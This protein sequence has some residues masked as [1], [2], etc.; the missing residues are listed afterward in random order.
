MISADGM[1][2]V[3]FK[4]LNQKEKQ[5]S[6]ALYEDAFPEDR[7]AYAAYYYKWKCRDNEIFALIDSSR[8]SICAMLHLNPYRIWISTDSMILHY[9]VAVATAL[10]YRR[11]GCMRRLML[12]AFFWL[13]SRGEPFTYLMPADTAYYEPFGFRVIYDQK[14]VSFPTDPERANDWAREQ[15]DVVTMR[16]EAYMQFLEEEPGSN[17]VLSTESVE[18]VSDTGDGNSWKPQIMCRI[19]YLPRLLT[20][21]RADCPRTIYLQVHDLLIEGNNGLYRW[22][23]DREHSC[24]TRIGDETEVDYLDISI[25]DLAE[26]LFGIAPLHPLLSHIRVLNRIC[27][28]EEV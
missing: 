17:N 27:I 8:E 9:I 18:V 28:N 21:L 7:G 10:P 11:K 22:S 2:S 5:D 6:L 13:Y 12:E 26:Q 14:P 20:C 15:F 16:D 19:I 23:V 3:K 24:V 1:F 25:E 4:Q